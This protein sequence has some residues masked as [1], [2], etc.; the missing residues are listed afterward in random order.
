[1]EKKLNH[2]QYFYNNVETEMQLEFSKIRGPLHLE[3][4]ETTTN[5]TP[6]D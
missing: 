2:E 3:K 1:M 4:H 6:R 5:I